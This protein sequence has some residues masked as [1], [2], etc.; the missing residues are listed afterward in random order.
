MQDAGRSSHAAGAATSAVQHGSAGLA[1]AFRHDRA[2]VNAQEARSLV[3]RQRYRRL[4]RTLAFPR[5]AALGDKRLRRGRRP[6]RVKGSGSRR[7][8]VGRQSGIQV[9]YRVPR[10]DESRNWRIKRE[11]DVFVFNA[12]HDDWAAAEADEAKHTAYV[13]HL[14]LKEIAFA[15]VGELVGD[16]EAFDL[17]FEDYYLKRL[18][19]I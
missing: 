11:G 10:P 5:G 15:E 12:T 4:D 8:A 6:L 9:D 7:R 3:Q 2:K 16:K 17:V 1:A 19:Q 14:L 18:M 13:L